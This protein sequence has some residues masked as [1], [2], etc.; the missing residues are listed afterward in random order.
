VGSTGDDPVEILAVNDALSGWLTNAVGL[1]GAV[2][3]LGLVIF[4]HELGHFAVAKWCDVNVERFSIGFGPIILGWKWGETEYAL[5]AI[6]FGGYVKMLGQ[7]DA[8]PSQMTSEE[9]AADPRSYVSKNVWQRMAIISAGV[10]MNVVTAIL[11]NAA[12]FGLGTESIPPV[13]GEVFSGYPAWTAGVHR[14]DSISELN[15]RDVTNYRDLA[16]N[17][18]VSS[19]PIELKGTRRTGETFTTIVNPDVTGTRPQIGI[20]PTLSLKFP[21]D[22]DKK[23]PLALPGTI[24]A[25]AEPPF[26]AGDE[27]VKV[28][29]TE[30]TTYAQFQTVIA[31][32]SGAAMT[33]TVR[34]PGKS[35]PVSISI[36]PSYFRTLGL[37]LDVA[38][39]VAVQ[40][41]SVAANAGLKPDDRLA[42]VNGRSIGTELDPLRLPDEFARLHG[43]EV[44]VVFT[45]PSKTGEPEVKT[46]TLVPEN[47]RGWLEQPEAEGQPLSIPAIGVAYHVVPRIIHVEPNSPAAAA[48]LQ[49]ANS[50]AIHIQKVELVLPDG[51][52]D[53]G[54]TEKSVAIKLFDEKE[55][56]KANNWGFAFW[57]MQQL[58]QR[59]VQLTI[60]EPNQ[61][62]PRMVTLKPV[63]DPTWALP[64]LFINPQVLVNL[65]KA[66]DIGQAFS[67]AWTHSRNTVLNI[68]L[69]LR[70]LA[71]MRLSIKE[72]HGPFGIAQAAYESAKTGIVS[73]LL[74]LGFLSLNLAV[75]NFLPIPVLDG[76]HMVFLTWEA[77]TRRR[78]SEKV[79]IG[80]TYVG[81]AFLLSLMV[82]VL[83][84]DIFV[85]RFGLGK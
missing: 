43:E 40:A 48:G 69:T 66:S 10:T 41:N 78:P 15:G 84:L 33:L 74:F 51:A 80:A 71:T 55:T 20:L 3:G 79:M 32:Q 53:D 19:G 68:Y 73:L 7:D 1:L 54:L 36:G 67:M 49:V 38:P 57:M 18:A 14:G 46:I 83:Y 21:P 56:K 72:L 65:E 34:R 37:R 63:E 5:S 8:D 45:R 50:Q 39:I 28:G 17:I 13:I 2:L 6:P 25:A 23:H 75:L 64:V 85:H 11:F 77:L 35:E 58:P 70:S 60:K 12:A 24:A 42:K 62:Q 52:P 26:E 29:E 47:R 44:E 16:L 9:I 22:V 76:G 4:L 81:M 82:L 59:S 61:D 30:V 31:E 27:I